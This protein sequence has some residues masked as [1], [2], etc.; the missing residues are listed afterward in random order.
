MKRSLLSFIAVVLIV[1]AYSHPARGQSVKPNCSL[2]DATSPTLHGVRLGMSTQQVL[3]AFAGSAENGDVR[4]SLEEA[5][6]PEANDTAYLTFDMSS[7]PKEKK[8]ASAPNESLSVTLYKG[9]VI[10]LGA[11][12][13]GVSF[14]S[15]DEWIGKLSESFALPAAREWIVGPSEAPNK[16]LKCNGIEIEATIEGGSASMRLRN[17]EHDRLMQERV[18]AEE[19]KRRKE[20]RPN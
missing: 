18:R 11:T 1:A 2:T 7:S 17:T 6:K 13:F 9:R 5:K 10:A 4:R 19:E 3:A 12:Y 20:F 16:I 8:G 15:L 14:N